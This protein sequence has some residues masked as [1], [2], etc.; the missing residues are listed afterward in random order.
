MKSVIKVTLQMEVQTHIVKQRNVKD[1]QE[2]RALKVDLRAAADDYAILENT[3]SY[4][5][6]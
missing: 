3:V 5:N 2:V 4:E 6:M 1:D